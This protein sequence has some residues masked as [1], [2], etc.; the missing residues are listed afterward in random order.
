[1][2]DF[3][4]N[5]INHENHLATSTFLDGIFSNML[6]PLILHP[7]R[8]TSNSATLIDNIFTNN[9]SSVCS[10][11]GL[12]FSD[13]SDHLPVFTISFELDSQNRNVNKSDVYIRNK[14][15]R[16]IDRFKERLQNTDW[17]DFPDPSMAYST[18][19]T[20]FKQIYE[21]SFPIKRIG[22]N[23]KQNKPWMTNCI[24]K[25]IKRK[26]K[27]Y[28]RFLLKPDGNN[29]YLYKSYKNTLTQLIRLA[30]KQYYDKILNDV[31]TNSKKTWQILNDI[32]KPKQN[33][34]KQNSIF[35]INNNEISDPQ[36][37]ANTFCDYFTSIGPSLAKNIPECHSRFRSFLPQN[38]N[39][40]SIFLE[41]VDES[42]IIKIIKGFKS[43]KSAG[44]D[45]I[46]MEDIK[47]ACIYITHPLVNIINQSLHNGIF[48]NNLKIARVVPVFKTGNKLDFKNYRPIS[49]LPA[50]SKIFEKVIYNR[51]IKFFN[52]HSIIS[53]S[54]Y[55]FRKNHSTNLALIDLYDK[56]STAIDN[57]ELAIGIFLD[58]SKAFDTVNHSILLEKLNHYGV[59]GIALSLIKSYLSNR[60]QYVQY[61]NYCS[62]RK[63]ISCGIPQG[64]ILGPLLFLIYINDICNTSQTA[65]VILFADDTNL[66]FSHKD[67]NSLITSINQDLEKFSQWFKANKL[68]LNIDK[69]KCMLFKPRQKHITFDE[70]ISID[71]VE[72]KIVKETLFLGVIL[73]EH[74]SWKPHIS[75]IASKISKSIGIIRK[76]SFFLTKSTLRKLYFSLVYPY[77]QYCNIVWATTYTTNLY[78]LIILQ[79]RVIRI[80]NY[81]KY[82]AHTN[83]IF[84]DLNILKFTDICRLQTGQFMFSHAHDLLPIKFLN[85][86]V[87]MGEVHGYNTRNHDNYQIP[88]FR[89]RIR[90]FSIK[91][92]GPKFYNS[93]SWD[94]KNSKNYSS[95]TKKLKNLFFASY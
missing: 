73:D 67:L 43:S 88:L 62:D 18:F 53:N 89:T 27:L 59:R 76:T 26:N 34:N 39:V 46:T 40:H 51:L 90:Q 30:K 29:E 6:Y 70:K 69:T 24:L 36:K 22:K 77:L 63:L 66:F 2:G 37:I 15:Q 23:V 32:I 60:M 44:Y 54:Q 14:S 28:K 31:K 35:R 81:S 21:E 94:V 91:Y 45:H 42:E 87:L 86:F 16:N 25:S 55:G 75:N 74:I 78:R 12:L 85:M 9:Y 47:N 95:F 48:P 61:N 7:T 4:I 41:P 92:E 80:I 50:F 57:R 84:K 11:N 1:M 10:N 8:I 82:D 49:I 38:M 58:L 72:I 19:E 13:I 79:K 33:Q 83:P 17:P 68:S 93:L 3:N 71:N 5:L 65:K 20:I 56:I 64:S 52:K